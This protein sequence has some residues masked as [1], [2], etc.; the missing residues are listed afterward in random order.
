MSLGKD[1]TECL[2]ALPH[3]THAQP[4][5]EVIVGAAT[6]R[7]DDYDRYSA[8]L[9]ELVIGADVP[10]DT[11]P[12]AFLSARAAAIARRLSFLEEPLAVWELDGSERVAQL[13]SSPPLREENEISYWEVQLSAG[14]HAGARL[15]RYRWAPDLLERE[16]VPYPATYALLGRMADAL[17]SALAEN[18]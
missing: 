14:E 9:R 4:V 2:R 7:F 18:E 10:T 3:A 11:A 12:R 6:V 15:A 1:L 5:T 17:N 13:R 16:L 8:T